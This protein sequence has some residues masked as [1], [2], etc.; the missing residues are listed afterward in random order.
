MKKQKLLKIRT[1]FKIRIQGLGLV[2]GMFKEW[3]QKYN[4]GRR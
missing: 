2:R 4:D 3:N 1:N